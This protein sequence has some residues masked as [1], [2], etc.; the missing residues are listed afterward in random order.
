MI[1]MLINT[2]NSVTITHRLNTNMLARADGSF[3]TI[4]KI[5]CAEENS[6]IMSVNSVGKYVLTA[7]RNL[8]SVDF[9]KKMSDL[10]NPEHH[11]VLDESNIDDKTCISFCTQD[12]RFFK[13]RLNQFMQFGWH[14]PTNLVYDAVHL[15][16]IAVDTDELDYI[17]VSQLGKAVRL[18]GQCVKPV[19]YKYAKGVELLKLDPKD[20]IAAFFSIDHVAVKGHILVAREDC[21]YKRVD[22]AQYIRRYKKWRSGDLLYEKPVRNKC[23][24]R[25][26]CFTDHDLDLIAIGL[27]GGRCFYS[28]AE[29]FPICTKRAIGN[30]MINGKVL[31]IDTLLR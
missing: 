4:R 24:I 14:R 19:N 16:S 2:D 13:I 27:K 15:T 30:E 25:D 20:K 28:Y 12:G 1:Y 10:G 3:G 22:V 11:L 7:A 31:F 23:L 21:F 17:L 18:D 29:N 6:T 5:L 26:A 9:V 8:Q